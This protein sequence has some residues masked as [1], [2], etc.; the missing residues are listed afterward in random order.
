M[1]SKSARKE[2]ALMANEGL[3]GRRGCDVNLRSAPAL[4]R[5]GLARIEMRS[6]YPFYVITE[7]GRQKLAD[8][9]AWKSS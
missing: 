1:L 7:M 4:V 6:G 9:N 2:L 5:Q 3:S 8:P